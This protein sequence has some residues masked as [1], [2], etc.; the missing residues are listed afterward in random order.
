MSILFCDK[1]ILPRL[2]NFSK[3]LLSCEIEL[4]NSW[5]IIS[6]FVAKELLPD[7]WNN[8]VKEVCNVLCIPINKLVKIKKGNKGKEFI[9]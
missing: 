4:A 3:Q 7:K 5:D 9:P 1:F 8:S 2:I 6:Y